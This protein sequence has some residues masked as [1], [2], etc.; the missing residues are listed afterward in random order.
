MNRIAA[1]LPAILVLAACS[2][3][4]AKTDSTKVA[5]SGAA[6]APAS[7]G[8]F[9]PATH[10]ATIYAKDFAFESPD[11]ITSGMT[12][13]H[14]VNEG[15]NLHHA[16]LVRLDSGK[17]IADF[18]AAMKNPG[19]PP[20]WAVFVGGPNAPDPGASSDA[21]VDLQPGNYAVICLVDIPAHVPHV[22]KGMAHPLTVVA[23]TGAP[24]A[25]PT[26][27]IDVTLSDYNFVIKGPL[28]AGKHTI[29]VANA[30][31]QPHE[32]EIIRLADGKTPKDLATWM[33]K[34]E[35]PPPAS[36]IGGVVAMMKDMTGYAT[37]DLTPGNYVAICLLP[38]MKDG[39]PHAAH[40]MIKEFKVS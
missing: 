40:G 30:G 7:R 11:T 5:Q 8:T 20:Q 27:D 1:L 13:F 15:P 12:T 35:G 14:L 3:D 29:K 36:A 9:D 10:T 6:A 31:P 22:M 4:A 38:D 18:G 37:L 21:V 28:T 16:Q 19:P 26:A 39:K 24:A 23:S 34:M 33:E 17:T 25:A 2:K 32:L